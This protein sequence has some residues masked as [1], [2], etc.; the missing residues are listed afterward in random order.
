MRGFELL[1][2]SLYTKEGRLEVPLRAVEDGEP[3]SLPEGSVVSLGLTFRLGEEIEGV[4]FEGSRVRDGVVLGSTRTV[5]G[6]F[7]AGGPYEVRLPAERLPVGRTHCGV[8]EMAGRFQDGE[9]RELALEHHRLRIT[10][11]PGGEP[12]GEAVLDDDTLAAPDASA[13]RLPP[14][15]AHGA[16]G[17]PRPLDQVYSPGP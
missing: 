4:T 12:G 11:V 8:Y 2:V 9:G 6:S 1:D 3:P 15:A 10:H 17:R 13:P 16:G 14:R 7:R 5:L